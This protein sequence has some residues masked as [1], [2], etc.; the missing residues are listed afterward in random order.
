M[1]IVNDIITFENSTQKC[2]EFKDDM[3]IFRLGLQK[4]LKLDYDIIP[5]CRENMPTA[6]ITYDT[7]KS[8]DELLKD[9]NES[10]RKRTKKAIAGGMEYSLVEKKDYEIFFAKRQKTAGIK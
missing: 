10:C 7:T 4:V 8:D 6:S 3:K 2:D 5:A 9:M 1:G